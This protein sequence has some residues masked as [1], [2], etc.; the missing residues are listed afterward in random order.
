MAEADPPDSPLDPYIAAARAVQPRH[1]IEFDLEHAAVVS[2]APASPGA[3]APLKLALD[4]GLTGYFKAF[5][6]VN[7][8]AAGVHGHTTRMPP[9]LEVVAWRLADVLAP[10]VTEIVQPAVFREVEVEPGKLSL[11]SV[12]LGAYGFANQQFVF[13]QEALVRI[14]AFFDCLIGQQDRH[15]GNFKFEPAQFRLALFDHGF[16]FARAEDDCFNSEMV[17]VRHDAGWADLDEWEIGKLTEMLKHED[18]CGIGNMLPED[19]VAALKDRAERMVQTKTLL[20]PG[21]LGVKTD[22]Q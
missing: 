21:D 18:L 5:S 13:G 4:N 9:L 16:S 1:Q 3:N 20:L 22:P 2:V 14:A 6:A 11:G 19:R 7:M 17:R 15:G 8:M 10:P 12:S